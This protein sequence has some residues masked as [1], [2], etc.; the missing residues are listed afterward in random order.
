MRGFSPG[1]SST[2]SGATREPISR[3]AITG[4]MVRSDRQQ[5]AISAWLIGIGRDPQTA[6]DYAG[7]ILD[8]AGYLHPKRAV[9]D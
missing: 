3:A 6:W 9:N 5:N 8:C 7:W 4:G 1:P 2:V